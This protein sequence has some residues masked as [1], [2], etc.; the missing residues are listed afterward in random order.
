MRGRSLIAAVA[1][2][3]ALP[4]AAQAPATGRPAG[5]EP[6]QRLVRDVIYNEL[7][8]RERDSH[9]EY[10]SACVSTAKN[11][12]REQVETAEGP[13]F[14][15][16]AENGSALDAA[17]QEKEDQRLQAYV[18]DPAAIARAER[19][20]EEDENHLAVA[21]QVVPE[22]LLFNYEEAPAGKT[23]QIAFRPNPAYVPTGYEA[24]IV[25]A[26]SGTM[27]VDLQTK[28]LVEMHGVVAQR[29]DFGFGL[30]GR[31]DQGGWF[32]IHRQQVSAQHWKTDLVDVHLQAKVL[33]LKTVSKD[34]RE[35][36]S[37]FRPVPVGTTPEQARAMLEDSP[38]PNVQ[39]DLARVLP[40]QR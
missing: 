40:T 37:D 4:L 16:V 28:R 7:H 15:V 19:A 22:A 2:A 39:A 11:L 20:H 36:R 8:D 23:V 29:V 3:A 13:V 18:N 25:Q 30:L 10:R 21:M 24:K 1:A 26:L 6:A 27:T 35:V 34:Q 31:V 9:W 17:E 33:L 14:R 12:V 32:R 38:E 5:V